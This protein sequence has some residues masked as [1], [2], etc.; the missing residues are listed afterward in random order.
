[1]QRAGRLAALADR[2][3][4]VVH[5]RRRVGDDQVGDLRGVDR[6][7]AADGHEPVDPGLERDVGGVLE[8]L[9]RRL[10]AGAVV[11][12]DLDALGLDRRSRRGRGARCA[13]TP[14][15][16]T[17]SARRTPSRL[18]SQPASATAPGPNLIG[19][20]SSVKIVSCSWRVACHMWPTSTALAETGVVRPQAE[21][22][23]SRRWWRRCA[24][25]SATR[26]CSSTPTCARP[27]RRDWTGRF[28]GRGRGGRPARPTSRR[29]AAIAAGLRASTA[30]RSCRRAATP[31]WSARRPACRA[32]ARCVLSLAGAL[33]RARRGRP[34]VGAGQRGRRGHAR[35]AAA[36]TRAPRASTRAWT[37]PRATAP[38]SAGWWP[39]TPAASRA[40]RHGTARAR[41][42]G[43]E[44]VLA[45]G[46]VVAPDV[47]AAQGQRGLRPAG[48][49][50]RLR[51]HARR[52]HRRPLAP[53]GA[54]A[55]PRVAALVPLASLDAAAPLL[56]PCRAAAAVAR[57][58]RVLHRRRALARAGP[59]GRAGPAR[60]AR[61]PPTCCWSALRRSDPLRGAGRRARGGGHRGRR[62]RRRHDEPRA[63]VAPARGAHGGDLRRRRAAQA[64][65]RRAAGRAGAR[66]CDAVRGRDA[67]PGARTIL[68][69]HLG[70]GNVH[71][72]VLGP[73]PADEAVDEAVLRARRRAAAA[74]SAPSTASGVA[75]AGFLHLTRSPAE[76]A[77]MRAVK[78]ALDPGAC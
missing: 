64:R 30:P 43:L 23:R 40:L 9:D 3:V 56:A 5:D 36:R 41:V 39:A 60:A 65:R 62:D 70:D 52:D 75:K 76:I 10:H 48:A 34:R 37:S 26:T 44:A 14:G 63:P 32:A 61:A 46:T 45:D 18:S 2:R 69:G 27:T 78:R 15:S 25:R 47:R 22:L 57:G 29:S 66:S 77:A 33:D 50:D 55:T 20:A 28:G 51:G 73:D 7:A 1:M 58:L 19:V 6:R 71:V 59:P 49:A 54:A 68:F 11:D 31:G 35:R 74:R 38:R 72:N 67:A 16:V 42:A 21:Q 17:S 24:A 53:G 8:R 4:D 12:D 13:A